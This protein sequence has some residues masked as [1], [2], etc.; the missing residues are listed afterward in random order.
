MNEI[1]IVHYGGNFCKR[2]IF[3]FEKFYITL[4]LSPCHIMNKSRGKNERY[5]YKY[6]YKFYITKYSSQS[7]Q[8][9]DN[10]KE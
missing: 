8:L 4:H 10:N 1:C 5:V 3:R 7:D 2:K 6:F 9:F